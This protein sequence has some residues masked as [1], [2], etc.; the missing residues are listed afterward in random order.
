MFVNMNMFE[1]CLHRCHIKNCYEYCSVNSAKYLQHKYS[2]RNFLLKHKTFACT[3]SSIIVNRTLARRIFHKITFLKRNLLN[4]FEKIR[5]KQSTKLIRIT[6]KI[7]FCKRSIVFNMKSKHLIPTFLP[8]SRS[9]YYGETD[10]LSSNVHLCYVVYK[11]VILISRR[12]SFFKRDLETQTLNLTPKSPSSSILKNNS[13]T[14]NNLE[15]EEI[16]A[17]PVSQHSTEQIECK[18]LVPGYMKSPNK[19]MKTSFNTKFPIDSSTSKPD[20]DCLSK[21]RSK[22][23]SKNNLNI[24][25]SGK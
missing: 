10:Y 19:R 23:S 11:S 5:H 24:I 21:K 9:I 22:Q 4:T 14:T 15:S 7:H 3:T 18:T 2:K 1:L 16:S 8:T 6:E 20:L 17:L 13:E 12:L 25:Q